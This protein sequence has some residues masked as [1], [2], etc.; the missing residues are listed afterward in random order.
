MVVGGA[1]G[2]RADAFGAGEG[3]R[4]EVGAGEEEVLWTGLGEER[5]V[6]FVAKK[7]FYG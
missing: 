6:S 3:G 5:G 7:L 1:R 4:G 2:W